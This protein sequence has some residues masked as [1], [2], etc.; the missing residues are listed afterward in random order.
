MDSALNGTKPFR[1]TQVTRSPSAK[2][3]TTKIALG[4]IIT[5]IRGKMS[6]AETFERSQTGHSN[7]IPVAYLSLYKRKISHLRWNCIPL[8]TKRKWCK[9]KRI[10]LKTFD[11]KTENLLLFYLVWSIDFHQNRFLLSTTK[12]NKLQLKV[13]DSCFSLKFYHKMLF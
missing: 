3:A 8:E 11:S 9:R 10:A 4:W 7:R 12:L 6:E 1:S 13:H 2:S 5:Q